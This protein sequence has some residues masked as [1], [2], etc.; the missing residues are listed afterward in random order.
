MLET[1]KY[2]NLS[3]QLDKFRPGF[4]SFLNEAE[5]GYLIIQISH[6]PIKKIL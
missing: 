4:K 1:K 5:D 6:L 2:Q 3:P